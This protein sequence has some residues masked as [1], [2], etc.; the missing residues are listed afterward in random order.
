MPVLIYMSGISN[1]LRCV[2]VLASCLLFVS[3]VLVCTVPVPGT[4]VLTKHEDVLHC[5]GGG[6]GAVLVYNHIQV[7]YQY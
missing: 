2:D 3:S 5:N 6:T 7:Q 4:Q 1:H